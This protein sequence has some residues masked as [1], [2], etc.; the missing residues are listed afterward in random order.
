MLAPMRLPRFFPTVAVLCLGTSLAAPL[1]AKNTDWKDSQG[2]QFR[3]EPVEIFGPFA[4]FKT[5]RAT[6]RRILLNTLSKEDC[7]RFHHE[8]SG[9]P[10]RARTWAEAKG[11]ATSEVIGRAHRLKGEELVPV[12][13]T[14]MPE[15]ELLIVLFGSHNN[16]ESWGMVGNFHGI[17][18]RMQRVFPGRTETVFIGVN[19]KASEH[20]RIA[21]VT[22]MPWLV[23][24]FYEQD[25]MSELLRYGNT[26]GAWM[27]ALSRDGVPLA[28]GPGNSVAEIRQFVDKLYDLL[29]LMNPANPRTWKDRMHYH[30]VVRPLAFARGRAAP[31][32]VGD[33]LNAKGLRQ[34]GVGRVEATLT[35]DSS[36]VVSDVSLLPGSILPEKIRDVVSGALRKS[37]FLPAIE[38]GAPVSARYDYVLVVPPADPQAAAETLWLSGELRNSLVLPS[39]LVL[40]PI[41]VEEENFSTV[42]HVDEY[43]TVTLKAMRASD[44]KVSR[45]AQMN[46]FNTDWF[47]ATGGA[48]SVR[49][50]E[51]EIQQVDG[52]ELKWRLVKTDGGY[53]DLAV[54]EQN[55]K[56]SI[57]YAWTEFEIPAD[58]D[59]C[60]GVGSDDG[61]KIWLNGELVNDK[62]IRRSS[63]LDDDVVPL[64]LVKGKN[65]LLIKI[66]NATG[67]WSFTC[68]LRTP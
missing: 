2:A 44:G 48:G 42:D 53:V 3:G 12:D 36:G 60:L 34:Y 40:K 24:D 47:D 32:L 39:W 57:G 14:Q 43:G 25:R 29:A 62:W 68:R 51:G 26:E 33:P 28:G 58:M 27:V 8:I 64:R 18:H 55:P 35:V 30:A 10:Q 13:Y 23:A 7:V 67:G 54:G 5:G 63:R 56:T 21:S 50:Q 15:P 37:L 61:L 45:K 6:A 38:N 9:R 4:L 22:K 20:K 65:R 52:V 16:S 17:Y 19:H 46:A 31:E 49:P 41:R 59:A 66:Q 11:A 1:I